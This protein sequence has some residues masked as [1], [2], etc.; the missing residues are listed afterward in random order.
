MNIKINHI[1]KIE[2]HTGF[3]A[4]VIRGDVKSAKFEVQE[5]IRLIEGILIG[6]EYKDM[7]VIAQRICGICPVVHNLT[8][9]KAIENAMKVEVTPET[10]KL[11]R[12]MEH[13]QFIHSHALHL[14]FLSLADFLD[15]ENDL[16]LVKEYPEQTKM[17]VKIREY[18]MELIKI[19]GGRVVHPLTNEV[20]G[21]KKVPT[22]EELQALI[23]K[24]QETL[25]IALELAAFFKTIKTPNFSRP[26]EYVCLKTKGEYAIYDGDVTSNK[27]LF[28]DVQKFEENF[29][30]FQRPKEIVKRVMRDGKTSY[31]VGAIAR[32]NNN[33]EKLSYEAREYLKSLN[34]NMP[35]Y[36]PFHNV[37]YQMVEIV[38]C[39]EDSIQ[40]LKELT[41]ADLEKA[42]TKKYV[43]REG[44]AA[45]AVEAPRGTL[46][47]WV[48]IDPKGYIKNVNI[49]SPTAQFLTHLED[50]IAAFIPGI[51]EKDEKAME[52]KMRAFIR[53]YDPCISCAVH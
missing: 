42:I 27:G 52:R 16:Q 24:G 26:T 46:Y 32:V 15:I 38:H 28:V 50:D 40:L 12:V 33:A 10:E 39:V 6:R 20:G 41:H 51:I 29:H 48:D 3:M 5:G 34:F 25:P 37:L 4:S 35:D 21:F 23:I 36:N 45:A 13:A 11:R 17:A 30:E 7:P 19:I 47:Y 1:A 14:F 2:G 44:S 49:I 9:I 22:I 8:A 31:M 18:G 53:A 43:V